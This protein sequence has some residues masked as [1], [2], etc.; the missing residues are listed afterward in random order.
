M[1]GIAGY[2]HFEKDRPASF[3]KIQMMTNSLVHRG[4]DGEGLYVR[5]SL[6]LGH[7]RLAIID[8]ETG[9]Q[10]VFNIDKSVV[11]IF[12][13]EIYNYV[14]LREELIK[15]GFIFRTA[16]DTE[17]IL[18]AYE[19]WGIDCITH[20]NGAWAISIWDQKKDQLFLS[21]DR[22]GEKPL[23]YTVFDNTFVFASEMK[24]LFAYGVPLEPDLNLTELYFGLINIP[25]PFTFYKNIFQIKPANFLLIENGRIRKQEYWKLPEIDEHNMLKDKNKIYNEFEYLLTDAVKI[26]MRS[27]VPFGAFLSG[28]LD[29][30]SVVALMAQSTNLPVNTFT[31]GFDNP[32]YDESELALMVANEFQTRHYN[33]TVHPEEFDNALRS[34]LY[35]YDGPFGDSS[36][37]PTGQVSKF[38]HEH[39]KMVL[40]GDGGDEVLSG[41][42]SYQGVKLSQ[43]YKRLPKLV[44]NNLPDLLNIV[45]RPLK[46]NIRFRLDKVKNAALTAD[47]DFNKRMLE[48]IPT[49]SLKTIK[50][51][52]PGSNKQYTLED[53]FSQIMSECSYKDDF[54]KLM[55]YNLRHSLPDDMLTKVDRMSMAYSLEARIPF[56]DHRIIEFMVGVDK[57]IKMQGLERKS[58]LKRTIGRR[59]PKSL[60]AAP[61]KG[62]GI[63]FL[64]WFNSSGFKERMER[65]EKSES[66]LNNRV[67][68][69]LV[70]E[71]IN[72]LKNNG[73]IIWMLFLYDEW[74]N[75]KFEF[76]I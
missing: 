8:L 59:L 52:I 55:Y 33:G 20:F 56:L 30:S 25:A 9:Q 65:L 61:K 66:G 43:S 24:A 10:P 35:H 14:E 16:S 22:M 50:E 74:V 23:Y 72:G 42:V 6:A 7:R 5:N 37:V 69:N 4:P 21:R 70:F 60:L 34:V 53:Y 26:R 67:I 38:A 63:P 39:V 45:S 18:H 13:G 32:D 48:K 54:Y 3:E 29:S 49:T 68:R 19:K 11:V 41:Y 28:G 71:N 47:L 58:I 36:A 12:N 62:F 40:T 73:N 64:D 17:V 27:D 15:N 76:H 1:C 31:I 75:R 51:I 57:N 46:G 2:Y 44:R